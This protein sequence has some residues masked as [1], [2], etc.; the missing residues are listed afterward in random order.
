MD[1]DE[2]FDIDNQQLI[3]YV[4]NSLKLDDLTDYEIQEMID[5]GE[6]KVD[7][8][9]FDEDISKDFDKLLK[10]IEEGNDINDEYK[11]ALMQKMYYLMN[12]CEQEEIKNENGISISNIKEK[13][14]TNDNT[15]DIDPTDEDEFKKMLGED[16]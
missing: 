4:R 7:F 12:H 2:E 16:K 8:F 6:I 10:E 1:N 9:T 14:F 5:S 11:N 3:E 13:N 15:D